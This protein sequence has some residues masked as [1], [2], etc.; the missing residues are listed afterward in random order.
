MERQYVM[1]Y[2]PKCGREVS[3]DAK[4]CTNCGAT[5]GAASDA[6]PPPQ[7]SGYVPPRALAD[8]GSRVVAGIVDYIIIGVIAGI[9]VIFALVPW[10]VSAPL[11]MGRFGAAG[12]GGLFGILGLMWLLWLIYFTYFEG[13]SGQTIGKRLTH[14]KVI[15]EDGS[16]CDIASALVRNV[17]RIVDHLPFLYIIGIILIAATEKRQR[18]GDMLGRTIVIK[19]E[20]AR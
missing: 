18:L 16:R 9:L 2:C 1:P 15:K 5:L 11:M 4:F 7:S 13:T 12:L 8:L 20:Q 3:A 6:A 19:T 17:L 14:I 10:V